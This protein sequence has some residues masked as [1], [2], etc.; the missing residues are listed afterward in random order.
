M[1][2]LRA[3][4]HLLRRRT[5]EER[6]EEE[7]RFHLEMETEKLVREGL[8]PEEARRR[9]VLAF[10]G[11]EGH[12]EEMRDGRTFAWASGLSLDFKL[13]WRMLRRYP[14]LTLVGG[15]GMAVAI[16]VGAGFFSF[17]GA[18]AGPAL[19][20]DEGDRIVAIQNLD[21]VTGDQ[22]RETHLHDLETWREEL[23][24]VGELGAYRTVDR[25]LVTP[26]GQ[27]E[28]RRIAEMTASGFRIARVPPLLGR[29]LVDDDE[30]PGAA[31]VV[32]IGYDVWQSRFGGNPDVVGRTI[33]LGATRYTV[34][35]VMPEGF[36]FPVNNHLWAPLRLD[37]LDFER[38][39]APPIDVFGRLAPGV[40]LEQAQAQLATLG[41]RMA[42]AHP[43]THEHVR[44]KVLPYTRSFLDSPE[45]TWVIYLV[46]VLV[47]MLLVAIAV[48]V[49]ILV[50]AR[51]ATR[52]GEIAM[53]LTLGASR[54]RIV[55]QLFAEALV[56]SAL[57][58]VAGLLLA[59]LAL[60]QFNAY[61]AR[62]GGEQAP[63]WWKVGLSPGTVLY[64]TGLAVLAAVIVGVLPGLKATGRRAQSNLR[65][66]G[67]TAL[68]MGRTW[69]VL[70]VAQVAVAVAILP[71]TAVFAWTQFFPDG[72]TAPE[73]DAEGLL[74]AGLGMDRETPPSAEA[75]AYR[76][77]LASRFADRYTELAR[78]LEA[79]PGVA[80]VTY[81][82]GMSA[83][84][85]EIEATRPG[86]EPSRHGIRF[87]EMDPGLFEVF[88]ARV[89][90]GRPFVPGDRAGA[91]TAVVANRSFVE[92]MLGG[93][94]VLGRRFRYVSTR[95]DV[96]PGGVEKGGWYE[97]VGVVND[98]PVELPYRWQG[99]PTIYHVAVPA[100]L[101]SVTLVVRTRGIAPER[102]AGRLRELT[103]AVDPTLR[104]GEVRSLA[105]RQRDE[106]RTR[107]QS[108]LA[109]VAV[110]LS[111]LL[112][113]AAGIHALMSFAV[114]RRRKEIGIRTA[115]GAHP[116]R[117]LA[118]VFSRAA[119]Q[120]AAGVAVGGLLGGAF[121]VVGGYPAG[122]ATAVLLAVAAL[123]LGVG[124]LAAMGPARRGLRVQ[125]ME[126]LR[127]E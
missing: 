56:L 82:S 60:R 118:S 25:N 125:P 20:L 113:S 18:M 73:F 106:E 10:G 16:A 30:R 8:S 29:Y 120:L 127:E 67:G 123:M 95:D 80:G 105:Q 78:R 114:A 46:Q 66:A 41:R 92:Q 33:R 53:R 71:A 24:T 81:T 55:A 101:S 104:L 77:E 84:T 4:L 6:M 124:L 100:R 75:K 42:A 72:I 12:K 28:P 32:V 85:I 108:T 97:I 121:I 116:R 31:P 117:I 2:G 87:L 39:K 96:P 68:R 110:A 57:S 45:L 61:V 49:A 79:E 70:I 19:P 48:N 44:P 15:L 52:A 122:R 37:P 47:G 111:V 112:L 86:A 5:A 38:G 23:R 11:V 109:V 7:I 90:A 102:L 14:G 34:V 88:G 83:G 21:A 40:T 65:E 98:F 54:A 1:H 89:I 26:D 35:G 126:A 36:A 51:T 62:I 74:S 94:N 3:R 69:T 43:E 91:A 9:A 93:G 22:A 103:L 17:L 99:I 64:V 76:R 107:R 50:Y 13:G 27:S 115:L 63:F 119:A 58:A 59:W